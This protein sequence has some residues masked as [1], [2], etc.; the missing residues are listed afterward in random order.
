MAYIT[1]ATEPGRSAAPPTELS[2]PEAVRNEY[3]IRPLAPSILRITIS[4][5][6]TDPVMADFV[7]DLTAA[8]RRMPVGPEGHCILCDVSGAAIQSR[9]M[10]EGFAALLADKRRPAR[11]IAFLSTNPISRMQ[12]RR[13]ISA[14]EGVALFDDEPEA[15]RWLTAE[16]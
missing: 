16:A 14:R 11:R 3:A 6:W 15:V 8:V 9:S 2:L 12:A 13:M 4:G 7:R 10:Y 5:F 1:S